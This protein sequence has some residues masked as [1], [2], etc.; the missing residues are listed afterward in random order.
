MELYFFRM[1]KLILSV[2]FYFFVASSASAFTYN[3][4]L[5]EYNG[6]IIGSL[7]NCGVNF[8]VAPQ[9]LRGA[10]SVSLQPPGEY[11]YAISALGE[12]GIVSIVNN[13]DVFY[14]PNGLNL[15]GGG[16]TVHLGKVE[17]V[18]SFSERPSIVEIKDEGKVLIQT[19]R[20]RAVSR[21]I[22]VDSSGVQDSYVTANW[23]FIGYS[24]GKIFSQD[25]LGNVYLFESLY[26]QK[27]FINAKYIETTSKAIQSIKDYNQGRLI[28]ADG[29]LYYSW[30]RDKLL[31]GENVE[32]LYPENNGK[33]TQ[34]VVIPDA[35]N[36]VP[37][38]NM[39]VTFFVPIS[40]DNVVFATQEG[41]VK[42]NNKVALRPINLESIQ[43][44]LEGVF[45]PGLVQI[46]ESPA[47]LEFRGRKEYGSGFFVGSSIYN[48]T[49]GVVLGLNG[50]PATVELLDK[51]WSGFEYKWR[52]RGEVTGFFAHGYDN[53][54][55]GENEI[56]IDADYSCTAVAAVSFEHLDPYQ[57][58][59]KMDNFF[60]RSETHTSGVPGLPVP[61]PITKWSL[62][63]AF[64]SACD[65][66]K[67]I[68]F[69]GSKID[70][71]EYGCPDFPEEYEIPIFNP[72][73]GQQFKIINGDVVWY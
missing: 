57:F 55:I 4:I 43:E 72:N 9:Y 2:I 66:I 45:S 40:N 33:I 14:S 6:G 28:L 21:V 19:V 7:N 29:S 5:A 69:I 8:S 27:N 20:K 59:L 58:E 63:N 35:P 25:P 71:N 26:D 38:A 73:G 18:S 3:Q 64:L 42:W 16:S 52:S 68:K 56:R 13:G 62:V 44:Q 60:T 30:D 65:K 49:A 34:M 11:Y 46:E 53:N 67:K 36:F 23:R 41:S 24:N 70:L 39:D 48:F 32:N 37:V 47:I 15:S 1:N 10:G 51:G 54:Y 22:V 31:S 50:K 61:V 12:S 17:E